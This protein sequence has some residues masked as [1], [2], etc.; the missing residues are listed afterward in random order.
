MSWILPNLKTIRTSPQSYLLQRL[1]DDHFPCLDHGPWPILNVIVPDHFVNLRG[2]CHSHRVQTNLNRGRL[3][4]S[5]RRPR[6]RI[7]WTELGW[8]VIELRE[9][10]DDGELIRAADLFWRTKKVG[11]YPGLMKVEQHNNF[12][13][14]LMDAILIL[15]GAKHYLKQRSGCFKEKP[16]KFHSNFLKLSRNATGRNSQSAPF[17]MV[18][19]MMES[20]RGLI[21]G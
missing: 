11:W 18:G 10:M 5:D 19:L 20:P 2:L 16:T 8:S 6:G 12:Q 4:K 17:R 3:T 13:V 21:H 9:K 7:S 1:V 15:R 14:P